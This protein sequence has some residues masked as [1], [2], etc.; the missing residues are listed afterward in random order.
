M[1]SLGE[2]AKSTLCSHM[3]LLISLSKLLLPFADW[4][5][6]C[7]NVRAG[8]L[9]TIRQAHAMNT[10]S[11]TLWVMRGGVSNQSRMKRRRPSSHVV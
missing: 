1:M 4:D 6:I 8:G 9:P 11:S 3:V 10:G 2:A 7:A 5:V